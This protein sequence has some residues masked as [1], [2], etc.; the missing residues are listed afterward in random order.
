MQRF[1]IGP[2][3]VRRH[4][5]PGVTAGALAFCCVVAL[6]LVDLAISHRSA[7]ELIAEA[8]RAEL[9]TLDQTGANASPRFAQ[10]VGTTQTARAN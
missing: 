2:G 6:V 1:Q 3:F 9:G 4:A 5:L 8:A 7:S 10:P